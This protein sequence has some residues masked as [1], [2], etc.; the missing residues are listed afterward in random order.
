MFRARRNDQMEDGAPPFSGLPGGCATHRIRENYFQVF[1]FQ[2]YA[3]LIL[4]DHQ[5]G[6]HVF[7][8]VHEYQLGFPAA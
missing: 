8:L 2:N 6:A 4:D 7:Q 5:F 1:R 3:L